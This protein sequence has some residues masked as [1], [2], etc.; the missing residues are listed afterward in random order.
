VIRGPFADR[1][2]AGRALG[3]RLAGT[4]GEDAVVLGLPRGGVVVAAEV[5]VALGAPLD[6]VLVRKLGLP[7]QPE[8]AMGA[9][10]SVGDVVETVR[11][12]RVL[13]EAGVPD[14]VFAQVRDRE[15]AELLRRQVSFRGDRPPLA[16]A[17]RTVVLVDDGMATG[18][19]A[20]A[21]L[22]AVARQQ[23][24][25]TVLAVPVGAPSAVRALRDVADDVVCLVVPSGFRAVG[26]A[27]G[28]FSQ[29]PDED[30]RR[31][32]DQV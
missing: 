3:E 17:G 7:E 23:P 15:L 10:A 22:T 31:L 11:T 13:A 8:L 28:D 9:I 20:R 14:A 5:A 16:L 2:E 24:R 1:R 25:R 12:E 29:T 21:A 18:A 6:V 4:V 30:V 27:Y 26:Q 32:L 19:T